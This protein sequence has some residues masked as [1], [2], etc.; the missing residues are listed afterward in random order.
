MAEETE[1]VLEEEENEVGWRYSEHQKMFVFG[2]MKSVG[3]PKYRNFMSE[4][5][6]GYGQDRVPTK[7]TV[8]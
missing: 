2:T 7:N 5:I 3:R 6:R 1:V 8:R 4:W